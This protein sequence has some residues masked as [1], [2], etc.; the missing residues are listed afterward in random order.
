MKKN[1]D[2][3][4]DEVLK[5]PPKHRHDWWFSKKIDSTSYVQRCNCEAKRTVIKPN[6]GLTIYR[7]PNGREIRVRK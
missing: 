3:I 5:P 4:V 2:L 7:Y 6:A 1:V